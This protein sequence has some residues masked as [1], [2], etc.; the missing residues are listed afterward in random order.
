MPIK[1]ILILTEV[2]FLPRFLPPQTRDLL[3]HHHSSKEPA[4]KSRYKCFK[5]K[6]I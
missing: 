1:N 5:S 6:V 4:E 2:D 3:R